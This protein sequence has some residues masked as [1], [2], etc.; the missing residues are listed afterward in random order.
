MDQSSFGFCLCENVFRWLI[1]F[2]FLFWYI[3]EEILFSSSFMEGEQ[4][5]DDRTASLWFMRV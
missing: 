1:H 3:R 5:S 2:S 4:G